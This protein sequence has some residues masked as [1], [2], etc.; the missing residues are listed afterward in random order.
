MQL[1]SSPRSLPLP[2]ELRLPVLA[3][4]HRA[5][6]T[7]QKDLS[8]FEQKVRILL[9]FC[10]SA[11]HLLLILSSFFLLS[12]QAAI[13]KLEQK[14]QRFHT[15]RLLVCFALLLYLFT[16]EALRI[17]T[18]LLSLCSSTSPPG[19]HS[20]ANSRLRSKFL[21]CPR[22]ALVATETV[23]GGWW[24]RWRGWSARTEWDASLR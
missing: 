12:H 15:G 19:T 21:E 14:L 16:V 18:S 3:M 20:F 2:I 11:P 4:T 5:L 9:C 17:L 6:V 24:Q 8:S 22:W 7:G 1:A 23:R 13:S 10:R